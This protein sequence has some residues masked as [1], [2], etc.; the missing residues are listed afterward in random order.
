[1][2]KKKIEWRRIRKPTEYMFKYYEKMFKRNQ[3]KW[4]RRSK[5][6]SEDLGREF[7]AGEIHYKLLGSVDAK[8]NMLVVDMA[9]GN[10]YMVHSDIIDSYLL[11]KK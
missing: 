8:D 3:G 5:L 11:E 7:K 4:I 9:E 10:Y 1:M 2:S 6:E